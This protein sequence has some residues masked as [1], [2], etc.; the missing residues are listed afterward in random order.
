MKEQEVRKKVRALKGLYLELLSYAGVNAILILIWAIF[1]MSGV[2]WPKY[3]L[4]VWGLAL[5]FK[6]YRYGI[7]PLVFHRL[8]FLTPEWEEKKIK[9]LAGRVSTQRKIHLN[10]N[11]K[12]KIR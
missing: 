6:A 8:A 12:S 1:D 7:L 5:M 4:V 9:E 3:V 2:F 11:A 10:R